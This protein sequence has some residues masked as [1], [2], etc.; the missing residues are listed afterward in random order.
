MTMDLPTTDDRPVWDLWLSMY[1]L[2]AVTAAIE[3]DVFEALATSPA[4]HDE[5]ARRLNLSERATEIVLPLFASLG[6]LS[7]YDGR[8]QLSDVARLYLLRGSPYDWG[9]LLNR[10]GPSSPHHVAIR[11]ALKGERASTTGGPGD[12]PS[13]AWAAGHVEIEQARVIA[14][15]MHSHSIAAALGMARNVDFSGV[16][17]LLD[18]GGG[19]GCF[20]IALA[21]RLPRLRCTIMEL[22]AMCEVAKEYISAAGLADRIE[23]RA[24]DMFRQEWPRDHDAM[25][26]SNI[27]HDWDFAT[28]ARLLKSAHGALPAGGRIF[29]HEAL[30]DDSG[31]GPLTTATF[32][33]VMLLGTQGRQFTYAELAKLLGDAGFTDVGA[34]PSHGY[35]S[36]VRATRR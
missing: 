34:T 32:S 5:L 16:R 31:A 27:L 4:T 3:L 8:Y 17:R 25:F 1:H 2:P 6:L 22:P 11:Q 14:A 30:L 24:V 19:S 9:A 20:C 35:Y 29:I 13:D 26:F 15:F 12:R 36:V 7:R 18:V 21:Q 10:M 33:L 28:C 23:T